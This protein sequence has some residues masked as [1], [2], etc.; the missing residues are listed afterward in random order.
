LTNICL[1]DII[2]DRKENQKMIK[3]LVV[4]LDEQTHKKVK[5]KAIRINKSMKQVMVELLEKW[6]RKGN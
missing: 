5:Q 4:E 3:R 6:L 1:F 2:A